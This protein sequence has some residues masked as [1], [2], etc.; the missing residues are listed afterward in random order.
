MVCF[1]LQNRP[2]AVD[3]GNHIGE[4]YLLRAVQRNSRPIASL[5]VKMGAN[6]R[7]EG[8]EGLSPLALPNY[9]GNE[10]MVAVLLQ[11][12]PALFFSAKQR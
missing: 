5:C 9:T 1:I 6:I 12:R 10:E 11:R 8:D 4:S 2:D 7:L 3:F